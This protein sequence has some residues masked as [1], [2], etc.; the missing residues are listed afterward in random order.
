MFPSAICR[1]SV[2]LAASIF[3]ASIAVGEPITV[4]AVDKV[5]AQVEATQAGQTRALVV[6]SEVYFRDR[7]HSREGARLQAT[8]KDGTQ[9]TLGE[10]ATVVVDEF[11]YDSIM[12]RGELSIR[13]VKGAF[14]YVGGRIEGVNGANV[15][16]R[17]P[18]GAI[19]LRGTTVWGGPIDNGYGVIVLS[20]EVTVTGR[21]G[22]VT[23]K[24][25]QGTMLFGDGKPRRAA[26][27]PAGRMKRPSPQSPSEIRRLNSRRGLRVGST[28][29]LRS[30]RRRAGQAGR[31][32][33]ERAKRRARIAVR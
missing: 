22:T 24:Q 29:P 6:K 20:G 11:I 7:C 12:S 18:V 27:W 17:T 10:N 4:G 8:L 30:A 16:I 15:Q 2:P 28:S 1:L 14:L 9:L 25:G 32:E 33:S 26:A 31:D 21:R 13:V 3:R 19:G 23:L 5:Q